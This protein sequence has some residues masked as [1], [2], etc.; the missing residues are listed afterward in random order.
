MV[1]EV[2]LVQE[3]SSSFCPPYAGEEVTHVLYVYPPTHPDQ[4]TD[5]FSPIQYTYMC[6]LLA[7]CPPRFHL[8]AME[9]ILAGIV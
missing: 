4:L 2:G 1:S 7:R 9:K 8:S 3:C 5:D 6:S